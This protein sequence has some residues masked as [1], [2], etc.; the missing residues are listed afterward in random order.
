MAVD[1]IKKD[2]ELIVLSDA[3]HKRWM[4]AFK[5]LIAQQGRRGEKAG[6][7]ARGLLGAYGDDRV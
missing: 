2:R 4:D 6:L 1:Q 7:P 5:P 3:E